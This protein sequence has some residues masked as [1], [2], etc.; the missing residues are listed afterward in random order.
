MELCCCRLSVLYT[1][2]L[3]QTAD[4][5]GGRV[6]MVDDN[7]GLDLYLRKGISEVGRDIEIHRT[8]LLPIV[9][10]LYQDTFPDSGYE[11]RQSQDG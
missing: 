8:L 7:A 6:R 11:R 3:F 1:R 10:P 4:M 9:G 5:R 2:T